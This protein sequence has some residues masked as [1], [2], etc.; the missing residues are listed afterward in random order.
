MEG[1]EISEIQYKYVRKNNDVFRFDSNYFL[2]EFLKE[3]SIIRSKKYST[4]KK[5]GTEIKS[6][7]AYSL[8]ND[9]HYL[10]T[11]I[12]FIRGIN[13]KKGRISFDDMIYINKAANTIL[14]KSEVKPEMVLLSMS[15]TIGD[16][17]LASKKWK[18][19]I[20]SNQDI[21]KIE[22]KGKIN[23]YFLYAFLVSKYGQ[24]YLR[25]EARGSVQ[26]HV[27]LSQIEQF[28]IPLFSKS[29]VELI[30]LTI[31]KSDD[32]LYLAEDLYNQAEN[33][34][35]ETIGLNNFEPSTDL[36]NIKSFKDSFLAKGRLDAE[37]YQKK[38]EEY[39]KMIKTN[40]LGYTMLSDEYDLIKRISK[41]DEKAYNYIEIGD[42][43]VGDGSASYNLIN[44]S[45]LPANAK[46][47]ITK[48]DIL[49]SKV[50][51]NRGAVTIIDFDAEN[52]IVSGA[53]TVLREK[54]S[55]VFSNETLKV[56]LRTQIYKDWLLQYNIG[57]QYPV[58]RD[59]DILN[60]P[61]PKFPKDLQISISK[62]I[63]SSHEFKKQSEKLLETAKHAVE[64]A[65]EQNEENAIEFIRNNNK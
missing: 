51:P 29:L 5:I 10:K 27:F 12:P 18:Y 60:M 26:Q 39:E 48:G 31:E 54:K 58:I 4:I 17:A 62:K 30:Q 63:Q 46:I 52:I 57:T 28:E 22:T 40:I 8:N 19:P 3:E 16:V 37:Y 61:I 47:E 65:I 33:L 20:N 9:V 64:I 6:F 23:P 2:K 55:S 7:G 41:K 42:V 45:E 34:L 35:L 43:N 1:L 14:W 15:G 38:Y 32:I 44:T 50:R 24:N 59:E 11:G 21:A 13:M 49:I 25:R 56:L 36:V 53:F